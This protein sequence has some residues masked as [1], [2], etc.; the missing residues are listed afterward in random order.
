VREVELQLLGPFAGPVEQLF[1]PIGLL[2]ID[3]LD[4]RA[5]ERAEQVVQLVG[6]GD[7]RGQQLVDL[8]V[9]QVTLFFSD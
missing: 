4:P 7:V 1:L 3:N 6:R 5:A 8:V 9:E 2:G